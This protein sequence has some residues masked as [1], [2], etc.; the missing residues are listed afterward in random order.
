LLLF[1][2]LNREE[3]AFNIPKTLLGNTL[4]LSNNKKKD[5][6]NI[7][8]LEGMI[9]ALFLCLIDAVVYVFAS[10]NQALMLF[11]MVD[12]FEIYNLLINLIIFFL[13]ITGVFFAIDSYLGERNIKIYIEYLNSFNKIKEDYNKK[14]SE[15]IN[16]KKHKK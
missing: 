3:Y 14:V 5:R 4:L 9:F 12:N 8:L 10:P 16:A 13:I 2:A 11:R 7:Y 6:M 1:S 15:T